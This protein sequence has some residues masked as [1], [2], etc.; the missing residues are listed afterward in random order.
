MSFEAARNDL[1]FYTQALVSSI[2]AVGHKMDVVQLLEDVRQK[3]TRQTSTLGVSQTPCAYS[4]K[5][6]RVVLVSLVGSTPLSASTAVTVGDAVRPLLNHL[7]PQVSQHQVVDLGAV[8]GLFLAGFQL[9]CRVH[10]IG[11]GAVI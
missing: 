4:A 10:C 2:D 11:F 3:V 7:L 8:L 5:E 1:S 6:G 9:C